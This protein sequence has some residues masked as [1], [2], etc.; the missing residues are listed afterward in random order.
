[1]KAKPGLE[2]AWEGRVM[3]GCKWWETMCCFGWEVLRYFGYFGRFEV[4]S[5]GWCCCHG[6]RLACCT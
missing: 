5:C 6:Q 4:G 2:G 1:V 3:M